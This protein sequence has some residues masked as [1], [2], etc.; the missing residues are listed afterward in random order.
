MKKIF[1]FVVLM[2]GVWTAGGQVYRLPQGLDMGSRQWCYDGY[3]LVETSDEY[4]YVYIT[5]SAYPEIKTLAPFYLIEEQVMARL[6]ALCYGKGWSEVR[7]LDIRPYCNAGYMRWLVVT[8]RGSYYAYS[9]G[10]IVKTQAI[11]CRRYKYSESWE[12]T[13]AWLHGTYRFLDCVT[14]AAYAWDHTMHCLK[15][16]GRGI[17]HGI[18]DMTPYGGRYTPVYREPYRCRE[19]PVRLSPQRPQVI[20]SRRLQKAENERR[21]VRD[22]Q[23]HDSRK[24]VRSTVKKHTS[25]S[26]SDSTPLLDKYLSR[27]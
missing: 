4:A 1:L 18:P 27:K 11:P 22:V 8:N 16:I 6:E 25:N 24:P 12:K 9:D 10:T 2:L 7:I 20:K 23:Q 15:A 5:R 17:K 19:R 13:M 14:Y 3:A 21:P 26:N